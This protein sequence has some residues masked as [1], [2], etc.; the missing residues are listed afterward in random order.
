MS[1]GMAL[2]LMLLIVGL[3]AGIASASS[4]R[5]FVQGSLTEITHRYQG[6][7]LLLAFWSGDCPPCMEELRLLSRLQ[8]QA[9]FKM[10]LVSVDGIVARGTVMR[11]LDEM[12][13]QGVE[14]WVFADELSARLYFGIDPT[15]QG[16]LPRSEW[17]SSSGKRTSHIGRLTEAQIRAWLAQEH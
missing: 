5:P 11:T 6:R 2:L 8:T 12:Q 17:F 9:S 13:L 16:E 15:W 7:P 4:L 3:Q 10:V 14:N 1:R